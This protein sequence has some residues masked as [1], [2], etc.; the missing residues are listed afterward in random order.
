MISMKTETPTE[1]KHDSSLLQRNRTE[2]QAKRYEE[3]ETIS[4]RI[5]ALPIFDDRTPDEILGY[6]EWGCFD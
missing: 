1:D 5:A 2:A 4:N 6:N 3:L